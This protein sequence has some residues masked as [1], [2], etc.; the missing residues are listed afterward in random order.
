M[1]KDVLDAERLA[2]IRRGCEMAI[3]EMVGRDPYRAGNRGSH[4]YSFGGS[5]AYFGLQDEWSVLLDPPVLMEVM[6]AIFGTKD[7]VNTSG[8]GGGDF[9]TPGSTEYQHLH[10]DGAPSPP[11]GNNC[12]PDI[13]LEYHNDGNR[14]KVPLDAE[15]HPDCRYQVVNVRDLPTVRQFRRQY[16]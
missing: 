5:T 3:R 12:Y 8:A 15:E 7:F 14:Y 6:E 10:S 9:N 4:R 16:V 11:N 13:K 1:I 2:K